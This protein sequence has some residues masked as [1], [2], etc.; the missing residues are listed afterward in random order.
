RG[1]ASA[2]RLAAQASRP[3][4]LLCSQHLLQ[5]VSWLGTAVDELGIL[6]E[7][8]VLAAAERAVLA[9]ERLGEA[10]ELLRLDRDGHEHVVPGERATAD[11]LSH[12]NTPSHTLRYLREIN[13]AAQAKFH[14]CD[15]ADEMRRRCWSAAA[16][17][18]RTGGPGCESE[19]EGALGGAR[20]RDQ[21]GAA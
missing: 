5:V 11:D 12:G 7:P 10:R 1:P 2:D 16:G 20:D 15:G 6:L 18:G 9:G 14:A 3:I 17:A 21:H 13:G 19:R 8:G 4:S